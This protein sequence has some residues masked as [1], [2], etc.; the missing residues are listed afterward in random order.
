VG[1]SAAQPSPQRQPHALGSSR[2]LRPRHA[3][4]RLQMLRGQ[5]L[6]RVFQH[7]A[8][9][10][11]SAEACPDSRDRRIPGRRSPAELVTRFD[12]RG[13]ESCRLKLSADEVNVMIAMGC[14]G[15]ELR[16]IIAIA[17][18]GGLLGGRGGGGLGDGSGRGGSGRSGPG[19]GGPI[20]TGSSGSLIGRSGSG[21][22]GSTGPGGTGTGGGSG[23]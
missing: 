6:L 23:R 8:P 11:R 4:G 5:L 10:S 15:E 14:A 7:R 3:C 12:H 22:G 16:R 19:R 17:H 20:G 2:R 18:A 1:R 13:A 9:R 21:C